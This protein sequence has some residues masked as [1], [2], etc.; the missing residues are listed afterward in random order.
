MKVLLLSPLNDDMNADRSKAALSKERD[1]LGILYIAAYLMTKNIDVEILDLSIEGVST[2]QANK[3]IRQSKADI[4]G[5]TFITQLR[6]S[7]IG[8]IKEVRKTLPECTIV[9]G[10]PHTSAASEDLL[11]NVKEIDIAVIGEGELTMYELCRSIETNQTLS[12][13]NGIAY[14]EDGLYKKTPARKPIG[15]LDTLPFP[16]RNL[17]K[18]YNRNS[19]LSDFE[20]VDPDK[21]KHVTE[22][23]ASIVTSRSCPFRCIYCSIHTIWGRRVRY[24]TPQNVIKEVEYL[25]NQYGIKG[26]Y[27]LDDTFT[28]NKKR[29]KEICSMLIEKQ[30]N[31]TWIC[32]AR[33]SDLTY[34]LLKL[35]SESGCRQIAVGVESGS[36]RVLDEIIHKKINLKKVNK[37]IQWG[38]E[39]NV[40]VRCNFMISLPGETYDEMC[41]TID[42]IKQ[43]KNSILGITCILPGTDLEKA[44]IENKV[45]PDDFSWAKRKIY[46]KIDPFFT[47]TMQYYIDKIPFSDIFSL[48]LKYTSSQTYYN[49]TK[50]IDTA[51]RRIRQIKSMNELFWVIAFYLGSG[52]VLINQIIK[53]WTFRK[54]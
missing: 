2:K 30:F 39:L 54:F 18:R 9:T 5:V 4:V 53:K 35:M 41:Q 45:L 32:N 50:L 43:T 1:K 31:L 17:L 14:I 11:R 48:F 6:F 8:L 10:G 49:N 25:V 46:K 20:W 19:D 34:D 27:F 51:L 16:A 12:T 37:V 13:V 22:R 44:A 38:D 3:R 23:I 36:Q 47:G 24:R 7:A 29:V 15:D 28:L 21:K 33:V 52:T 42:M 26:I 40:G